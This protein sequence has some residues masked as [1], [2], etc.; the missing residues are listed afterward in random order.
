MP[1][2]FAIDGL[3]LEHAWHADMWSMTNT[4]TWQDPRNEDNDAQLLRRPKFKLTSL[5][6]RSFGERTSAGIEL[7]WSGKS[8]DV[9]NTTLGSYALV[10]LRASYVLTPSWKLTARVENLLDRDYALAYGFNTPGR[11]GFLDIVW[12]PR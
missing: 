3:E 1:G 4:A 2:V 8:Q 5:T 10:N 9:G 6:E 11:S 7:A 12:Q